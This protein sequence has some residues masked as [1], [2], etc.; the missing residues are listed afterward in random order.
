MVDVPIQRLDPELPLPVRQHETD[1]GYDL[2]TAVDI[3][4][5]P[6]ERTLVPT[7]VA[8]GIPRGYAGFVQPRSGLA[9]KHGVSIVNAPGLID[10]GYRGEIKVVLIN[11]DPRATFT[12][13]RGERIAQLVIQ[14]VEHVQWRVVDQLDD[15]DRGAG[16]HGST[17]R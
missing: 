7:G 2:V 5:A 16:G 15:S 4:L 12:A 1:A 10:S 11:L 17:G 9:I 3:E 13:K 8:I 14:R 6:G